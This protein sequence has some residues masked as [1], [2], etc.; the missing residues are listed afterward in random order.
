[1]V[2]HGAEIL[3]HLLQD[4]CV[5]G[6]SGILLINLNLPVGQNALPVYFVS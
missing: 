5:S 4:F 6:H 3:Q 1:M 2:R